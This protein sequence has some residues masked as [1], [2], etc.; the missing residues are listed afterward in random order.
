MSTVSGWK[1]CSL[2]CFWAHGRHVQSGSPGAQD[3]PPEMRLCGVRVLLRG[4]FSR[5]NKLGR[6]SYLPCD[7]DCLTGLDT[8]PGP[9]RVVPRGYRENTGQGAAERG[10][11]QRPP[12]CWSRGCR[13]PRQH[14]CTQHLLPRLPVPCLPP[15]GSL[16][17]PPLPLPSE[18]PVGPWPSYSNGSLSLQ[19]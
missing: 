18:R 5:N 17:L 4:L 19:N 2:R 14:L 11:A 8:G 9:G 10:R 13:W 7:C 6:A 3:F 16:R 12:S 1:D 15:R